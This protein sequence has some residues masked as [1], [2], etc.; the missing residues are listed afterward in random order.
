MQLDETEF[1]PAGVEVVDGVLDGAGARAHADYDLGGFRI[2]VVLNEM[3]LTSDDLGE[4]VHEGLDDARHLLVVLVCGLT[5]LEV[6]VGVLGGAADERVSRREG[7]LPMSVDEVIG[8]E[9]SDVVVREHLEHVEFVGGAETF[10]EVHEGHAGVH[11]RCLADEGQ[12][13]AFL[14][15]RGA[16]HGEAGLT[17][18]HDILVIAEDG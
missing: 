11:R 15:G 7:A 14:H 1:V 3:V 4:L 10:K 18:G 12:V 8:D 9:V 6:G 5:S 13:V 2:T 17:A 16:Q